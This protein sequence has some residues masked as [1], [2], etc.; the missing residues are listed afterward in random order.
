MKETFYITTPIYYPSAKLHIGHAYTTVITDIISRYKKARGYD[1]FFL[2]GTDEHGQKI[3]IAAKENNVT[4]YEYV[5]E[6]VEWSKKLWK[7]L[8]IENDDFIRTTDERHVKVVQKI[9]K[10]LYDQGDIY[11]GEYEGLYCVPCETF[12]TETQLADG[13]C[14][15]C[16]RDV[17]ILREESYFFKLSKYQD[18]IIKYIEENPDFLAPAVS[19]NEI[20][21]NFLKPGLDDLC[22]SRTSFK[23]GVPVDFD[24]GHVVY[25]WID[26]LSNYLSALGYLMDDDSLFQ[27]YWPANVQLLGKEIARFHMIIWP[28]MLMAL[29]LPLPEKLFAHGWLLFGGR[30]MSKSTGNVIDPKILIERYG[31]DALRYFLMREVVF[32]QDGNFSNEALVQRINSDLAN[33]LGNL[34]SRTVGMIDK[35]FGGVL[36]SE[37]TLPE[38]TAEVAVFIKETISK[39]ENN[40]DNL[41]LNDA[42]IEIWNII[43][44]MNKFTDETAPWVLV[45]DESKKA[46]LAGVLY[47]LAESLRVISIL[48][49]PI[50]PKTPPHIYEQLNINDENILTWDS[51][52]EFGL[53][54][55]DIKITKGQIVFPRFDVDKELEELQKIFE[56]SEAQKGENKKS[57]T[58]KKEEEN[59]NLITI[60]DFVKVKLK[61]GK[62]IASEKIEGTDKLLKSKIDMGTEVRQIVSGIAKHYNPEDLIGKKVCVVTNLKPVKLR[63]ELSEGMI[64]AA[65]DESG[66]LKIVTIDGDIKEGAEIK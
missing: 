40:M 62:I 39:V 7:E 11:K 21:N 25:V 35:Y 5:T 15:D 53:L 9:F 13:K 44:R 55:K 10:K 23:W 20:I 8:D 3:E 24:E 58:S 41:K 37:N 60:E 46:E 49:K 42:A 30:K 28:A 26:A 33:D 59:A 43:K 47:T 17:G 27:K 18:R 64:L 54:N 56:E 12:F 51:A 14:P 32:G 1:V 22:V 50:M 52:K 16:G 29:D 65:S 2:T 63:G 36:P 38:L 6:I 61:V 19:K 57:A 31:S 66:N 45:K 34:L 4:P 48:I